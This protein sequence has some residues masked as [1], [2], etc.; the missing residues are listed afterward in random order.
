MNIIM[1]VKATDIDAYADW[2]QA[3]KLIQFDVPEAFRE[4]ADE[5]LSFLNETECDFATLPNTLDYKLY[6]SLEAG[7]VAVDSSNT[8]EVAGETYVEFKPDYEISDSRIEIYANDD[9]RVTFTVKNSDASFKGE[10]DTLLPWAP[11]AAKNEAKTLLVQAELAK[12]FMVELLE[13]HEAL[14]AIAEQHGIRTLV[15]L[16]YLQ[17]AI[18]SGGFIDHYPDESHALELAR[19]LPSGAIWDTYVQIV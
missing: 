16:M 5:I 15:D 13:S 9:I 11:R 8:I 3:P 10:L 4:K 17:S 14:T 1:N 7:A 18:L 12:T 6:T 2:I 19:A